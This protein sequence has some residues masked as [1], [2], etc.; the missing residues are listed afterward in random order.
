L[1]GHLPVGMVQG[2]GKQAPGFR[3]RTGPW[4]GHETAE[5]AGRE[6]RTSLEKVGEGAKKCLLVVRPQP[7]EQN[8]DPAV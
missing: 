7:L 2:A 6:A 4:T 3:Y 5:C 8:G 1:Q